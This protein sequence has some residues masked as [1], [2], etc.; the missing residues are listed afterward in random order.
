MAE[1]TKDKEFSWGWTIGGTA[2]MFV[3]S[4]FGRFI[5]VGAGIANTWILLAIALGSY[6]VT[7]FVIGWQSE[8]R[9]IIEAGIA[10]IFS[11][12]ANFVIF[13]IPL[14]DPVLLIVS[15]LPFAAACLGAVIGELVQGSVIVRDDG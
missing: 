11:I 5:A 2:L 1:Y 9:T 12:A 7:G 14:S 15:A 10:A 8:G 4:W 3:V 13:G 6:A